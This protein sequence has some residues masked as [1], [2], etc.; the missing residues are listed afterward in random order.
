MEKREDSK[1]VA[2]MEQAEKSDSK[3][4]MYDWD[5]INTRSTQ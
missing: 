5:W 2:G 4:A 3:R 1:E